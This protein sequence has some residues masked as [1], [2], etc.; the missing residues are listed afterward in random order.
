MARRRRLTPPQS[1]FLDQPAAPPAPAPGPLS[2]PPIA[3]VAGEAATSAA[4]EALSEEMARA[5]AQ[6]RLLENLPLEAVDAAYLVRD[7][8]G[9]AP[10]EQTALVESLRARGQQTAIEVVDLGADRP[11]PRYGLISGWRRLKALRQLHE[12]TGEAR[13]AEIRARVT[14]PGET[15]EAYLA[16][17]EENEI[18]VGLSHYERA[19]IAVRAVEEGVFAHDRAAL[20]TLY[21]SASR[22]RK[23]KIRSFV[24]LVRQLDGAL[25]FPVAIGERLGLDLARRLGE[26][27]G[28]AK[29]VA[30]ALKAAAPADAEAEQAALKKML[31]PGPVASPPAPSA[32]A[33]DAPADSA[34]AARRGSP[35]P[36]AGAGGAEPGGIALSW[37]EDAKELRLSGPGVT[38]A[39]R[40]ALENW[41]SDR[42]Q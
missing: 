13:F 7:R 20:D 34:T 1:D 8:I 29:R 6:G 4:L 2:A 40:Q 39:F 19:R 24:A 15:S 17:V 33:A 9:V 32:E 14:R 23:S 26:E 28:F 35:A 27:P 25:S 31:K 5:R 42:S 11:G 10:E 30:R 41:L 22:A 18:R 3:Q 36:Q 16:M 12:E 21:A 38:P 37:D